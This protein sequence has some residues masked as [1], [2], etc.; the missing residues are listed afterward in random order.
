MSA[1]SSRGPLP[2]GR[3]QQAGHPVLGLRVQG[4]RE[5]TC[6][7]PQQQRREREQRKLQEKEQ[8]RREDMQALRREEERRQAE[9][10]QVQRPQRTPDSPLPCP[11]P[12][13]SCCLPPLRPK[14]FPFFPVP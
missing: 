5:S 10:E 3:Q 6:S 2:S 4:R 12:L 14:P 13:C 11:P 7:H 9:R 8:Q 1:L